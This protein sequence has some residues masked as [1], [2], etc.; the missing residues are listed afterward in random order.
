MYLIVLILL[1]LIL[2]I[3]QSCAAVI[4]CESPEL[5]TIKDNLSPKVDEIY[6]IISDSWL[7]SKDVKV[8]F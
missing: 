1:F 5:C 8:C 3:G 6:K 2:A 7:I 4:E